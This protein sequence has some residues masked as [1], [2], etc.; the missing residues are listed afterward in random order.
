MSACVSSS[1]RPVRRRSRPR[2]PRSSRPAAPTA[3]PCSPGPAGRRGCCRGRR[4]GSGRGGRTRA[5]SRRPA[6][7]AAARAEARL[8]LVEEAEV[9]VDLLVGGA[10]EGADLRAREAAAGLHLVGEEDGVRVRV[11]PAA[12]RRRRPRTSGRCSRRRRCGSPGAC[13]RPRRSGTRSRPRSAC[14][15]GRPADPR[16]ARAASEPALAA[17]E[18]REEQEDDEHGEAEPAAAHR[19]PPPP[20]RRP[21]TSVTWPVSSR[22]PLRKR[23]RSHLY[24]LAPEPFLEPGI[25]P[26][27]GEIAVVAD[28]ASPPTAKAFTCRPGQRAAHADSLRTGVHDLVHRQV[29]P[30]ED[31]HRLRDGVADRT[32]L[33]DRR[34]PGA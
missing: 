28:L 2:R 17:R 9:D 26:P 22:A 18:Q 11:L 30:R 3:R 21:R 13:S 23:M 24:P 8:E 25:R 29:G 34:R 20:M 27:S 7:T 4:A 12:A 10:V 31:V 19:Q 15:P 16:A 33:L 6:R 5:R 14:R 1:I 32:D